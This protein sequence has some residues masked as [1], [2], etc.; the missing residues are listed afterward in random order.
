M[1]EEQERQYQEKL[2]SLDA[3]FVAKTNQLDEASKADRL[4]QERVMQELESEK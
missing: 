2:R 1:V 3:E 4:D